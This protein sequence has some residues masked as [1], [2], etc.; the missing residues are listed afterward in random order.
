M[1]KSRK[2][3]S[4]L[5]FRHSYTVISLLFFNFMFVTRSNETEMNTKNIL[6]TLT[7]CFQEI[8]QVVRRKL[9]FP[10]LLNFCGNFQ[11]VEQTIFLSND[12][13]LWG[14]KICYHFQHTRS[15]LAKWFFFFA[16]TKITTSLAFLWPCDMEVYRTL[17]Y[18]TVSVRYRCVYAHQ[19]QQ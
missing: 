11:C 18:C 8:S 6:L 17:P 16:W 12:V 9:Q 5:Y 13:F 19:Q 10:I 2:T 14:R 7:M 1:N 4:K 15:I 3:L